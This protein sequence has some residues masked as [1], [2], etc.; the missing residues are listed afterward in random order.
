MVLL[1]DVKQPRDWKPPGNRL[2]SP[3]VIPAPGMVEHNIVETGVLATLQ[4]NCCL[5][6]DSSQM[7]T[8]TIAGLSIEAESQEYLQRYSTVQHEMRQALSLCL[9]KNTNNRTHNTTHNS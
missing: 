9:T 1:R 3:G 6:V 8:F 4:E 7:N 5:Y 2:H